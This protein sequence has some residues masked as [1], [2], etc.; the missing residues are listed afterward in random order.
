MASLSPLQC[1]GDQP[2]LQSFLVALTVTLV[3]F[4][5]TSRL[6]VLPFVFLPTATLSLAA[7]HPLFFSICV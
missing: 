4:W 5:V 6:F 1:L 3:V 2:F 7:C